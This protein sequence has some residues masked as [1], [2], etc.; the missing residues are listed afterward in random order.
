MK[1][2]RKDIKGFTVDDEIIAHYTWLL[3]Q[4]N[5]QA[6]LQEDVEEE[7]RDVAMWDSIGTD[8]KIDAI[9]VSKFTG[10][11]ETTDDTLYIYI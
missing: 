3:S 5:P 6:I 1:A 4:A 7:Y 2:N 9:R 8:G 11:I 10:F